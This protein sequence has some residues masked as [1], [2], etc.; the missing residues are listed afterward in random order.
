M[1]FKNKFFVI[2]IILSSIIS[3]ILTLIAPVFVGD[4]IEKIVTLDIQSIIK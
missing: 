4:V 1:I 3:T 2:L